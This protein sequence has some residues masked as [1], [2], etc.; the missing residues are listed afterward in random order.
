MENRFAVTERVAGAVWREI[1]TVGAM[2]REE[3]G[4]RRALRIKMR[5]QEDLIKAMDAAIEDGYLK[6]PEV[7]A[8][9]QEGASIDRETEN[10]CTALISA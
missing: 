8:L 7:I 4:R 3:K 1:T 5:K 6:A 10:G 2:G 9:C